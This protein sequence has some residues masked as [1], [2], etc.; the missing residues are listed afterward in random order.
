[1]FYLTKVNNVNQLIALFLHFFA[2]TGGNFIY[3]VLSLQK[4]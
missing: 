1:M 4:V 3:F 2:E